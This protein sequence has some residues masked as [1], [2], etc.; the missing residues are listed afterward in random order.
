M[1][2]NPTRLKAELLLEDLDKNA[3]FDCFYY[4]K[5][6]YEA[7]IENWKGF[8]CSRC[9]GFKKFKKEEMKNLLKI[10]ELVFA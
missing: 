3:F 9:Y 7:A 6:L 2:L 8:S 4:D 1:K 10:D 5:C